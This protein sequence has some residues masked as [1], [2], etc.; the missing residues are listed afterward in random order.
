VQF[1]R[2]IYENQGIQ[3]MLADSLTELWG[4]RLMLYETPGHRPRR[5]P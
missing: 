5:G 1:G 3:F 2:P 4:A